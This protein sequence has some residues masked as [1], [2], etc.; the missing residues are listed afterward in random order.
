MDTMIS[1]LLA[2]YGW[3]LLALV[4]IAAEL[5]APGY[6][7]LWIGLAAGVMGLVEAAAAFDPDLVRDLQRRQIV[8]RPLLEVVTLEP[9]ELLEQKEVVENHRKELSIGITVLVGHF[10]TV[11]Q[12]AASFWLVEAD[13]ELRQGG[14]AAAVATDQEEH[15]AGFEGQIDGPKGERM[16]LVV[17]P[18]PMSEALELESLP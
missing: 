11:D 16:L 18:I 7:L 14:L 3:W 9:Q 10:P 4:L 13:Q 6:F 1:N 8:G 2:S 15:F 5:L 12:D 17:P